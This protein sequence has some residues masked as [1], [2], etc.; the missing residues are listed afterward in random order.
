[1][2]E[3]FLRDNIVLV[4][5]PSAAEKV[6]SLKDL[7]R[8]DV[9]YVLGDPLAPVGAYAEQGLKNRG[10]WEQA[11]NSLRARP[12]TVNQ[13]A[14]MV[15]KDQVDAGLIYS[16][17]HKI[18][19]LFNDLPI[20]LPHTVAGLALLLASGR[21]TCGFLGFDEI[22]NYRELIETYDNLWLDTAMVLTDY[23][24]ITR[25]Y[26]LEDFRMDRILYGSDF[27]NIPY[28]WDRELKWL[29]D[30]GIYNENLEMI[31]NKKATT[32]FEI[33]H[34]GIECQ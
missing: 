19:N 9:T 33:E 24:P 12:S 27:P 34:H 31:L 23:F 25:H 10:I 21:K 6:K 22:S 29:N 3:K 15:K 13:V 1:M 4:I 2:A 20:A 16:S 30:P 5:V 17:V 26:K 32:F 28:A 7:T 11:V 8:S 18:A 14:I